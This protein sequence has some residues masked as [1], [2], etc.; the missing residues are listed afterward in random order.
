MPW[1]AVQGQRTGNEKPRPKRFSVQG[2]IVRARRRQAYGT[3]RAIGGWRGVPVRGF[4]FRASC[5]ANRC[6]GF[7]TACVQVV[8]HIQHTRGEVAEEPVAAQSAGERIE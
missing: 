3:D 4:A 7:Y 8:D 6:L 2:S 1:P 5:S